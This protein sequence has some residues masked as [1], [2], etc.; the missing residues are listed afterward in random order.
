MGEKGWHPS[1]KILTTACLTLCCLLWIYRP[2]LALPEY[3]LK[4]VNI[5]EMRETGGIKVL[6]LYAIFDRFQGYVEIV[7]KSAITFFIRQHYD[8]KSTSYM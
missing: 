7:R 5:C 3:K 6:A 8:F 1:L 4:V 2:I